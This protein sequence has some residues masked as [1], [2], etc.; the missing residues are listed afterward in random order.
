MQTLLNIFVQNILP[1]GIV[2]S[3]GFLLEKRF[4]LDISTLTKVNF[5]GVIPI[6]IF[7]S[8]YNA[9]IPVSMIRV[10]IFSLVYL[11]ANYILAQSARLLKLYS[12]PEIGVLTNASMFTNC[13]NMGL[14]IIVLVFA[15]TPYYQSAVVI[16][17]AVMVIQSIALQTAGFFIARASKA[18]VPW[19]QSLLATLRMPSIYAAVLAMLS[20]F[21]ETDLTQFFFWPALEHVH[22]MLIGLGLLTFGVQLGKTSWNIDA[23][24]VFFPVVLR[25]VIGPVLAFVLII[26]FRFDTWAAR[27]LLVSSTMPSGV[28]VALI[29]AEIKTAPKLASQIVLASTL[30]SAV[31]LSIVIALAPALF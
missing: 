9:H 12:Q 5:Y 19:K 6:F 24:K 18:K 21:I 13:G 7:V 11:V 8:L 10:V 20:K 14:P 3:I 15:A 25:L 28:N 1:V 29:A 23:K 4:T 16:Q 31:V 17:L 27:V 22:A 2:T 26:L 30:A